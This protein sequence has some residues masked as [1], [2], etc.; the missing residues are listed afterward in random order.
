M[1]Y[2]LA[3]VCCIYSRMYVVSIRVCMLYLLAYVCCI[4]SRMYVVSIHA[5]MLSKPRAL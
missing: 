1:L 5:C 2:L 4:Y 3:Y